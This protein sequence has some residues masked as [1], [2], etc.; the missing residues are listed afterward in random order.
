M[1]Q[2]TVTYGVSALGLRYDSNNFTWV[3]HAHLPLPSLSLSMDSLCRH[4]HYPWT[5]STF[6]VFPLLN[7]ALVLCKSTRSTFSLNGA[8]IKT[9]GVI[10]VFKVI[11]LQL[12]LG[13]D[14]GVQIH[15]I[16]PHYYVRLLTL[17]LK[18]FPP[19]LL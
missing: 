1:L 9:C 6:T 8:V 14:F 18:I 12:L 13:N 7:T 2:S 10:H 16:C 3:G 4:C 15:R 5:D 17:T 19:Q 11:D